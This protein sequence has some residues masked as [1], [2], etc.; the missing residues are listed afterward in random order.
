MRDT[1]LPTPGT[2]VALS[3]RSMPEL[4]MRYFRFDTPMILPIRRHSLA[5]EGDG[6]EEFAGEP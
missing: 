2:S 5:G 6:S 1:A 4:A 3:C